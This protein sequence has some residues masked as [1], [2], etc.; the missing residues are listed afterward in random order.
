MYKISVPMVVRNI[1][2]AGGKEKIYEELVR[3][4]ADRVILALGAMS[5]DEKEKWQELELFYEYARYFKAKGLKVAS[6]MWTFMT[7]GKHDFTQ[8]TSHDGTSATNMCCPLDDDFC[9]FALQY[10]R[11]VAKGDIDLLMLDDDFRFGYMGSGFNCTCNHHMSRINALVGEQITP[12]EL[13]ERALTGGKNK[14]R[15]A[16]LKVNGEA[17]LAHAKKIRKTVN[18]INPDLRIGFCSCISVW[19]SDGIDSI[20]LAKTL[21]G[22]TKPYM[23]LIGAPYWA[24]KGSWDNRLQNVIET[25][26]MERAWCG[27]DIEIYAEGD[28]YPRPR[29]NCP[30]SYLELFDIAIRA[31]GRFDGIQKYALDYVSTVDYEK[32]YIDRHIK[33]KPVYDFVQAHFAKSAAGVRVYEKM[34]KLSDMY[35]PPCHEKNTKIFNNFFSPAS[36]FLADNSVPTV[37]DGEGVCGIAFGENIRAVPKSAFKNGMIIDI[38]AAR[39]LMDSGVDVGI[40]SIGERT[41][42]NEEQYRGEYQLFV[43]NAYAYKVDLKDGATVVSNYNINKTKLTAEKISACFEYKNADGGRF[44]VYT[45][46]TYTPSMTNHRAYFRIKQINEFAKLPAF[47]YGNPDL[48]VMCKR[49]EKEMAVGLWNIFADEIVCP[50][51]ILDSSFD[52][53]ECINCTGKIES[54]KVTLTDIPPFSFAGFNVKK[55]TV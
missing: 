54:N 32:G 24:V 36:K 15:D 35:I 42:V 52:S 11:D 41:A 9:E 28:A 34:Q 20:T 50:E 21:A 53:I 43:K 37:Y 26:R 45:T 8:I 49:D 29:L 38:H 33:N 1:P 14:Y 44:L 55:S 16:W 39:I 12:N 6:W 23:R 19:D 17:L 10:V 27:D 48:Y 7:D 2:R 18:E 25:E 46:D 31:S 30:A 22:D 47:V 13:M 3:I 51:I 4:G 5:V 40:N